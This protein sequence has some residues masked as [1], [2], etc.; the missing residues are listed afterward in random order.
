VLFVNGRPVGFLSCVPIVGGAA[1]IV[2]RFA[3]KP[4]LIAFVLIG[5]TSPA[6]CWARL[7]G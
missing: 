5:V 6:L 2:L 1:L 4:I 7:Q 3:W